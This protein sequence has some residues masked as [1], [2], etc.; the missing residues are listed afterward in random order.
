[1]VSSPSEGKGG[2]AARKKRNGSASWAF[3]LSAFVV[4][5]CGL[6]Y[7]LVSGALA[8]YL[9]GDSVTQFSFVIGIYLFS[10]GLGSFLTRYVSARLVDAF[11]SAEIL[12]GVVG[13]FSAATLFVC[14]ERIAAFRALLYFF[15]ALTGILV[16]FEI[17]L[18]MRLLKDELDFKDLVSKVFA[19]DYV[20]ALLA[21]LLFPLLLIPHLGLI[22]TSFLFGAINVAVALGTLAA[23]GDRAR[24]RG[25]LRSAAALALAALAAGFAASDRLMAFSESSIFPGQPIYA[26]ST[27]YQRIVVTRQDNDVRLFL[28]SHLQFSSRDEYRYHEAL[29]HPGLSFVQSPKRVLIL[30][31]GDGMAAREA[32]KNPSVA[33]VQLVDLDPAMTKLFS[34]DAFLS[35][36]N[37]QAFSSPRLRAINADAFVWLK[38]WLSDRKDASEA[39]DFIVLDFPD[40]ANYS[41]GKLYTTA[42]FRLLRRAV[43][44][45]GAVVIQSTSPLAARKSFWCVVHTLKSVGF[46]VSPYHAYVPSF[47]EWGFAIGT[48]EPYRV[49]QAYPPGLRFV[50][51]ETA[52]AFFQFPADMA[53]LPT[54]INKLNNQALV[55]Y[56]EAE[57]SEFVAY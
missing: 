54:E 15:I 28:N 35:A 26:K 10:M 23:A 39:F 49:P 46:E 41:V 31:G 11:V 36:L 24:A 53:E 51:S 55:R 27:P 32:L 56:Y 50:S 16:G 19:F 9:L 25:P 17:P 22:R 43:A 5:T 34:G 33:S 42:F 52:K 8:S 1:M 6:V 20:G 38:G 57:W 4:S 45:G 13:G 12:V 48:P 40:P 30:G 29:I 2:R 21:S 3:L 18:L 7:E 47:G 44:P 37:G 14:F